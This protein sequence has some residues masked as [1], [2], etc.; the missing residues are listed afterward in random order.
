MT[1][2]AISPNKGQSGLDKFAFGNVDPEHATRQIAH[3]VVAIVLIA[4]TLF[5]LHREYSAFLRIRQA[6]LNSP[7]HGALARSRTVMVNNIPKDWL[8]SDRLRE[9]AAFT[10]GHVEAVWLPR[11]VDAMEKIFDARNK[12]CAKLEAAEVKVQQLAAKNKLKNK[13]PVKDAAA[14]EEQAPDASPILQYIAT[15]DLP[16]HRTGFLGLFG[17]KV[18]TLEYSP[19]FIRH[20]EEELREARAKYDENPLLNSAFIRFSKQVDAHMFAKLVK[21]QPGARLVGAAVDVVP[22]DIIWSNLSMSPVTRKLRT[23]LSWALTIGLIIIWS[24]PVAFVGTISKVSTLCEKL[25]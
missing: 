4:W 1:V 10:N 19:P 3:C 22:E 15:K 14:A 13:L 17:K 24:I 16:T 5:M 25:S 18:N 9:L 6:Y 2:D 12:E 8:N 23:V 11:K 7:A 20:R 21:Q